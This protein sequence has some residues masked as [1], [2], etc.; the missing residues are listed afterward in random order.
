MCIGEKHKI[1]NF[2][3]NKKIAVIVITRNITMAKQQ[4]KKITIM[5]RFFF[6][7]QQ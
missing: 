4:R 2:K 3:K 1:L 6:Q 5:P 7:Q